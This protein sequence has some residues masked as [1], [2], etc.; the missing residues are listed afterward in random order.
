MFYTSLAWC[1]RRALQWCYR[2]VSVVGTVPASGPLR[3][4]VNDPT[5]LPDVCAVLAEIPR[6]VTF[7]ANVSAA[8]QPLV[9][10]AYRKMGVVPVH[11]VRDVRKARARGEDSSQANVQA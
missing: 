9:G 7:V 6:R 10:W 1:A 2:E 3:L 11:R 5:D 8:E 4:A